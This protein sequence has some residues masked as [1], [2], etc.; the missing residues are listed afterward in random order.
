MAAEIHPATQAVLRHFSYDHLP[1]HLQEVSKPFH[2]LAHDLAG[3]LSGPELTTALGHLF[4]AKNWAVVAG[5]Q[6]L[7]GVDG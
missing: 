3:K 7:Q 5:L 1:A 2:D 6:C 4:D